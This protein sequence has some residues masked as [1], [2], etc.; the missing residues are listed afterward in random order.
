MLDLASYAEQGRAAILA[1]DHPRLNELI[2]LNFEVRRGI[3]NLDPRHLAMVEL[4]RKLGASAHYAGSGGSVIG[5]YRDEATFEKLRGGFE[6]M[7][8]RVVKPS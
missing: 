8:C 1:G 6:G 4:A 5:A 2:N 7:G 3:L